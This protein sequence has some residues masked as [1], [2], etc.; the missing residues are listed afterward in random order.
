MRQL[1]RIFVSFGIFAC[2]LVASTACAGKDDGRKSDGRQLAEQFHSALFNGDHTS[3]LP[4][5]DYPFKLDDR[6]VFK[7]ESSLEKE[8]KVR[9]PIMRRAV[10]AANYMEVLTFE[11]FVAGEPLQG[12][13]FT[14]E[15]ARERAKIIRFGEGGIIVRLHYRD[16]EDGTE[17][18]RGYFLVMHPNS[19]GDLKITT[20]Y[21]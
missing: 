10:R 16:K 2:L 13:S 1:T 8:L 5:V 7:R 17:D 12:K 15:K 19:V 20:Y 11:E 18:G 4:L 14:E 3:I 9:V 21:D 6:G